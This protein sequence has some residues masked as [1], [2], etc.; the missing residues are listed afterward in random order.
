MIGTDRVLSR[1]SFAE[2]SSDPVHTLTEYLTVR[3]GKINVLKDTIVRLIVCLLQP[4][5]FCLARC[6]TFL[7]EYQCFAWFNVANIPCID[8]IE[9]ACLRSNH[10][11]VPKFPRS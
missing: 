4:V 3:A 9:R 10:K 8:D 2:F 1:E 11:G 5:R 7:V 6:Q